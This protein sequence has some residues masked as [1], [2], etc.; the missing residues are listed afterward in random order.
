M[1][2]AQSERSFHLAALCVVVCSKL[3]NICILT[4]SFYSHTTGADA[5]TNGGP[6]PG[7]SFGVGV[8]AGVGAGVHVVDGRHVHVPAA[9][10]LYIESLIAP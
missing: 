6:R 3:T 2:A 10:D 8:G 9:P 4:A 5:N 1:K 7:S